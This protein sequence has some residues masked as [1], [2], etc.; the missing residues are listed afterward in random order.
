M[1][2]EELE[3]VKSECNKV[4]RDISLQAE[5]RDDLTNQ[6]H[7]SHNSLA[8]NSDTIDSLTAEI[9]KLK[10]RCQS[11]ESENASLDQ[12][13]KAAVTTKPII[14][15]RDIET[16]TKSYAKSTRHHPVL[17]ENHPQPSISRTEFQALKN[18]YDACASGTEGLSFDQFQ[19]LKNSILAKFGTAVTD[20]GEIMRVQSGNFRLNGCRKDKIRLFVHSMMSRV[21]DHA[22][23]S[24]S[25]READ[26]QTV[27]IG[28]PRVS[29]QTF[30]QPTDFAKPGYGDAFTKL[31]DPSYSERAPRTF[32][33]ILKSLRSIFDE[34]NVKGCD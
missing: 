21:M 26:A 10:Y 13:L 22:C 18:D 3:A 23:R 25:R 11:L 9:Q 12:Q 28:P 27:N 34:K 2:N 19:R 30:V 24:V 31:L 15:V 29:A 32:E 17:L 5:L 7:I 14:N 6:L 4:K 8:E 20:T 33:W 16:Q 1:V